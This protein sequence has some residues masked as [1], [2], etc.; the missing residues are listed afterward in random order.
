MHSRRNCGEHSIYY[1]LRY[2]N[3]S[4]GDVNCTVGGSFTLLFDKFEYSTGTVVQGDALPYSFQS[5]EANKNSVS[6]VMLT[7]LQAMT[8]KVELGEG[9]EVDGNSRD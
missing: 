4:G 6:Y 9:H 3:L 2:K 8:Q 5:D 1:C 7:M